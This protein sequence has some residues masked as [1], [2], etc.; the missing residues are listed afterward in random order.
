MKIF[1]QLF[2]KL[3]IKNA[4]FTGIPEELFSIYVKKILDDN[5]NILIVTSTLIEA[6][7]LFSS[8]SNYTDKVYL[9]PMDD[10]LTSEAI[11]ISPDLM[12]SRLETLKEI[13]TS[14]RIVITNLMGYLRFLPSPK[15][16]EEHKLKLTMNQEIN[17]QELVSRLIEVGYSRQSIVTRT[18]EI[19]V[20]GFV[21]DVF[22][23]GY[24]HPIRIEFFGDTIESIRYF[25][26]KTQRSI[27]KLSVI[28]IFPYT[29]MLSNK[30]IP[31]D[32]K[33]AKFLPK[34]TE[35]TNIFE[36]L[37]NAITI[38]KDEANLKI[39]YE[40]LQTEIF[41]YQTNKDTTFTENYMFALE[42]VYD[43]DALHYLTI[44]N[45]NPTS[46][47]LIDFNAKE[48]PLFHDNQEAVE[49][50]ISKKL[51]QQKTVIIC[52][53]D[54]QLRTIQK[55]LHFKVI[56][57]TLD[58]I[59]EN[60]INLVNFEMTKGF[61]YHNYVFITEYELFKNKPLGKKYK[62][63]FKYAS[64]ITDLNK[65]EI[66]DYV[67]HQIHGIGK[68]NGL[69]TL[70]QGDILKDYLEVLYQD[71]DKLYI[72]VEKIDLLAKYT[73]K[74]GITPKIYKLGGNQWEKVKNRVK[75]KVQ[76]MAS[77]LHGERCAEIYLFARQDRA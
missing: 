39:A 59:Y 17:P 33:Q 14:C 43:D 24:E 55:H 77:V 74:E 29:E 22:P 2:G 7:R 47:Q 40:Q 69:T 34:Y 4:A 58:N 10:F 27:S 48:L 52:L 57:T 30:L 26:E 9:F 75:A 32:Q 73:G 28:E 38:Y 5:H 63:K 64:K 72:P 46:M 76:D 51:S 11:A 25:D 60:Q 67:V 36:Y 65:L 12:V 1:D 54:Y 35:T 8:I 66:G 44:D 15:V 23:L 45:I 42:E 19:G 71:N 3:I 56:E 49:K 20:R 6:N 16:Y 37:D 31:D 18:G 50:F 53:R 41:E 61:E 13:S 21:V 68:Y 62:T 70:K